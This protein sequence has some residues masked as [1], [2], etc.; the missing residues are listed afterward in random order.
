MHSSHTVHKTIVVEATG[1]LSNT[2]TLH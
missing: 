1:R 2:T